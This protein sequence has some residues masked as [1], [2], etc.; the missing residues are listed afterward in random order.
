MIT[1]LNTDIEHQG[2][3]YHVQTE[4]T[5]QKNA[6][7]VTILFQSGAILA[8]RKTGYADIVK[9]ENLPAIL[10]DLMNEQHKKMI[11]DLQTGRI[12]SGATRTEA[13]PVAAPPP[14]SSPAPESPPSSASDR[15]KSLD[16]MILDY[17]A[18]REERKKP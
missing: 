12:S 17:L 7:I 9:A 8:T 13:K 10:K 18:A 16:D 6:T 3:I 4:D 1:G 5:G 14:A 11:E 2:K 15:K